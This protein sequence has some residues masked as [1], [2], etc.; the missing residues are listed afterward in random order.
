MEQQKRLSQ[1]YNLDVN[2]KM[3]ISFGTVNKTN[4][5]VVYLS[6][7]CWIYSNTTGNQNKQKLISLEDTVRNLVKT[8]LLYDGLFSQ[9]YIL[10]Y[11]VSLNNVIRSKR[12]LYINVYLKQNS[13]TIHTVKELLPTVTER[14]SKFIDEVVDD[15][16]E[17][18]FTV[19][20]TKK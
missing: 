4:P 14:A 2:N 15:L 12:F 19:S 18:G 1:T 13:T 16:E 10:D 5:V 7:G 6:L 11:D 8:N 17:N 20:K 9:R 3:A